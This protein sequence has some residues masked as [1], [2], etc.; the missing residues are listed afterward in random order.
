M[1]RCLYC[2]RSHVS[3]VMLASGGPGVVFFGLLR[4][5]LHGTASGGCK[6]AR[7]LCVRNDGGEGEPE[8]SKEGRTLLS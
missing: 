8:G 2:E 5:G 3:C 1:V 4:R 6:V 7:C